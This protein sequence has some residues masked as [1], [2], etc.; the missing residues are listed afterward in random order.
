MSNVRSITPNDTANFTPE[1]G[2]YKTLQPF[3]YWCQKVLPLV[4]DDSLSYYELLCKVVDYLNKT[5]EDVE[6]LHGDVTNLRTAYEKLQSYVNNYF[7]TL[8]V[9][10]EINNKLDNMASSG[11]LYEIIRRYTDPIVNEQNEKINVLKSRMDTFAS[12][13]NGSTTGDAELTDIRV[14]YNSIVYPSA[15]DAVR[16]Q[17]GE[18]NGDL[19]QLANATNC[20]KIVGIN[21]VD[22]KYLEGQKFADIDIDSPNGSYETV[23]V[24]KNALKQDI[25]VGDYLKIVAYDNNNNLVDIGYFVYRFV[26]DNNQTIYQQYANNR[27]EVTAYIPKNS[28]LWI[29]CSKNTPQYTNIIF[30][31]V[32]VF[33]EIFNGTTQS[34]SPTVDDYIPYSE[35]YEKESDVVYI[36]NGTNFNI[37]NGLAYAVENNLTAIINKGV[38]DL[39]SEGISGEGNKL[40]KH[41][42]G[43]GVTLKA[44]LPTENWDWSPLN[45][46]MTRSETIVEGLTVEVSNCRY[47][48]HDEMY[49]RSEPY[50]NVFKNLRLVHKT[51]ATSTLIAPHCIG[52][53][54]G[55]GGII[56]IENVIASANLYKDISYHSCAGTPTMLNRVFVKNSIIKHCVE[57]GHVTP[58]TPYVEQFVNKVYVS[59]C[60]LGRQPVTNVDTSIQIVAWNNVIDSNADT[61]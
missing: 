39:V 18:L 3:R 58:I 28:T 26:D 45:V 46:D 44:D 38:Y 36:G 30:K 51:G 20:T 25:N 29:I 5:M 13:P 40:P 43:Y 56:E 47:C 34:W 48:I 32:T 21:I 59:G 57:A 53:G 24:L 8:D 16:E 33:K 1:M 15:G 12:L 23:V 7:S 11:E 2:N 52:G 17:V 49:N 50:H 22:T 55:N 6:T 37:K 42:I 4:Y 60:I 54:L 10:E 35:Y 41:L 61:N 9:Q 19:T 27:T 14:G 31:G